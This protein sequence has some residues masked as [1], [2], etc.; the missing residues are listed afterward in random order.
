MGGCACACLST[1]SRCVCM[2][3]GASAVRCGPSVSSLEPERSEIRWATMFS[4]RLLGILAGGALV[5][6]STKAFQMATASRQ[7]LA[8]SPGKREHSPES[9]CPASP[10]RPAAALPRESGARSSAQT[11][12]S[13]RRP[14]RPQSPPCGGPESPAAGRRPPVAEG[15]RK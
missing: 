12:G 4:A 7:H 8:A 3:L 14:A 5:V 1:C 11:A 6:G 15:G 13:P 10:A 9:A 2:Q